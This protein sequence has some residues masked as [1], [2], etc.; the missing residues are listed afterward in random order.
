MSTEPEFD[1][2][3]VGTGAGGGVLAHQL[4]MAGHRVVSLEQGPRL[5]DNYFTE[6]EPPLHRHRF[7]IKANTCFPED[8]HHRLFQHPLFAARDERSAAPEADRVFLHYQLL[9]VGG[10]QNL[11][12]GVSVRFAPEDFAAWPVTYDD[13][14]PHYGAT[15]K[16]ITVCGNHDGHPRLPDGDYIPV[17]PFRRA[18]RLLI[19][20]TRA[21]GPEAVALANRK[22]IETRA[23]RPHHCHSLGVCTEGCPH[24]AVHKF[25]ARLL[26]DIEGRDNYTL[27]HGVK[28]VRLHRG[29]DDRIT[30]AEIQD[31]ATGAR[32][33][34]SARYFVLAAGALESPRILFNSADDAFPEGLAN[35]R[36]QVGRYL[37]DNPKVAASSSLVPLWGHKGHGEDV[38]YGDLL[39]LLGQ[40]R[41]PGGGAF[42]WIGH[43]IHTRP[44]LPYYL[45]GLRM[46]PRFLR[47][48]LARM[49][50]HSYITVALFGPGDVV[51]DNRVRPSRTVDRYGVPQLD[52]DFAYSDTAR[53]MMADMTRRCRRILRRAG[54]TLIVSGEDMPGTGIHYAG[55]TRMA[56]DPAQGVV[57]RDLRAFDHD[58]LYVCDGGAIPTLPD[59][60]LT[61]T[62]MTLAHR[63]AGHLDQRL[64]G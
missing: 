33:R 58:N 41:L 38:A 15:E 29:A 26:P 2:C 51:A 14:A 55:T 7:G 56:E 35:R 42:P 32:E 13:L 43:A 18:D 54:A 63:L 21:A 64:Q 47:K 6:I 31:L 50:F 37:Q 44:T 25:P 59:K 27:R 24:G 39:I 12:N 4:A 57:D 49:M 11:W 40:G 10:L 28:V 5:P 17:R 61:L 16:L 20:A 3:V 19:K 48:P 46:F 45:D 36:D 22:A 30:A 60:H 9:A 23:D 53:A 62:I 34:V 52:I 1:V 8:P